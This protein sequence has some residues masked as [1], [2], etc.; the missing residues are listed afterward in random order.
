MIL[1]KY[2]VQ[3]EL[4]IRKISC[5]IGVVKIEGILTNS[6]QYYNNQRL[7]FLLFYIKM[8]WAP[9]FMND[10]SSFRHPLLQCIEEAIISNYFTEHDVK[11]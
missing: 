1:T 10:D 6:L 5:L 11:A 7:V 4:I 3:A 9:N 8:L 2:N